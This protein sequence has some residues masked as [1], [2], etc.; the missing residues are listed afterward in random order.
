MAHTAAAAA[1]STWSG[2]AAVCAMGVCG[3][4][5]HRRLGELDG[6]ASYRNYIIDAVYRLDGG[7]LDRMANYKTL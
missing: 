5:A 1:S 3:E 7:T 4:L 2:L 6:S